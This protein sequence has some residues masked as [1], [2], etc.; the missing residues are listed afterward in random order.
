M[1]T[2]AI[3]PLGAA[4]LTEAEALLD[5]ELGGRRQ[6]RL[7]ELVDVLALPGFVAVVDDLMV[8]VATYSPGGARVELAAIAVRLAAR[9]AGVA[10][11]LIDAVVSSAHASGAT[12]LWL[13]TTNDNLDAIGLYQRRGFHL[14]ELHPGAVDA[15]RALKPSI[16]LVG[17]H[18]IALRDVLV[19]VRPLR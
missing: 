9:R 3:R 15:A 18:G 5:D 11:A 13:V 19:L 10:S 4:D 17:E 8:G 14:S 2:A 16:P 1:A 6:A 12:A 7:G